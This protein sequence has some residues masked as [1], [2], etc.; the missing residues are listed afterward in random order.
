MTDSKPFT[1]DR[2]LTISATEYARM[3]DKKL[4]DYVPH[5]VVVY[6]WTSRTSGPESHPMRKFIDKVPHGAE[7]V[8]AYVASV[9]SVAG[10]EHNFSQYTMAGTALVPKKR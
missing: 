5:G 7:V 1:L 8:V 10:N 9:A 2:V 6:D 4:S 3:V